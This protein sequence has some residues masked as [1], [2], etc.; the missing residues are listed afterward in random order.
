[1]CTHLDNI[2]IVHSHRPT[3]NQNRTHINKLLVRNVWC[4]KKKK[5]YPNRIV[6]SYCNGIDIAF[7]AI[8]PSIC[9]YIYVICGNIFLPFAVEYMRYLATQNLSC[10]SLFYHKFLSFFFCLLVLIE[11]NSVWQTLHTCIH[12]MCVIYSYSFVVLFSPIAILLPSNSFIHR[13]YFS[14][15]WKVNEMD[16]IH[17]TIPIWT[18][19]NKHNNNHVLLLSM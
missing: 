14:L 18:K 19:K 13:F 5:R 10:V 8:E 11:Y 1:M 3:P 9:S 7:L 15:D 17:K 16:R 6:F 2:I 4:R 12:N